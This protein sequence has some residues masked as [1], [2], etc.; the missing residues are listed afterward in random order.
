MINGVSSIHFNFIGRSCFGHVR[1]SRVLFIID[2]VPTACHVTARRAIDDPFVVLLVQC[3]ARDVCDLNKSV[4]S[5]MSRSLA[6][7]GAAFA[8]S[9]YNIKSLRKLQDVKG[10]LKR[11]V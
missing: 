7:S 9:G 3:L 4:K 10:D 5:H 2:S 1:A 11:N 8:V 6:I